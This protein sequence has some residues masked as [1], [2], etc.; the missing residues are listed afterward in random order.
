M[1]SGVI[2]DRQRLIH[3]LGDARKSREENLEHAI[4]W[5]HGRGC[6]AGEAFSHLWRHG[7]PQFKTPEVEALVHQVWGE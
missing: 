1:P 6:T 4:K 7:G 2:I 5:L 3:M